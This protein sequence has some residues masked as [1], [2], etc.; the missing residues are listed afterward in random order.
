M[1]SMHSNL[2]N[3]LDKEHTVL[4]LDKGKEEKDEL[5]EIDYAEKGAIQMTSCEYQLAHEGS[6]SLFYQED[7]ERGNDEVI[8]EY[9]KEL[10]DARQN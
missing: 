2:L 5:R 1:D 4:D 9:E 7:N 10:C 6:Q 3:K 8:K